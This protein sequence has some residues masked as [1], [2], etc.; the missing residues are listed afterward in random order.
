MK[1][2]TVSELAQI[3]QLDPLVKERM[4][5]KIEILNVNYG[6]DRSLSDMG[7]FVMYVD[8]S[9]EVEAMLEQFRIAESEYVEIFSGESEASYVEILLLAGS[10]YHVVLFMPLSLL[11]Y[12]P[13]F[14]VIE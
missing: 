14:N 10:D 8:N 2:L 4:M 7:G 6:E 3:T 9:E 1:I 13:Q 11:K 5:E 12:F